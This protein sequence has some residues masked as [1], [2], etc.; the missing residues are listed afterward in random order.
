MSD[1][2]ICK[3]NSDTPQKPLLRHILQLVE[4]HVQAPKLFNSVQTL[5]LKVGPADESQT[6]SRDWE[7]IFRDNYSSAKVILCPSNIIIKTC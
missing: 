6:Q 4:I 5:G 2:H 1:K 3:T 7:Q